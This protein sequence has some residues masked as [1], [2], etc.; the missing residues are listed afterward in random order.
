MLVSFSQ[1]RLTTTPCGAC[2][3]VCVRA[4]RLAKGKQWNEKLVPLITSLEFVAEI[5][6]S[7]YCGISYLTVST[8]SVSRYA[9]L[10]LAKCA[11]Q[12]NPFSTFV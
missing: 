2:M 3:C 9:A 6:E 11:R 7:I 10:F 5:Q 4:I 8:A 1:L 12:R